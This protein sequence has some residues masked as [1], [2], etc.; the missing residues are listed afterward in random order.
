MTRKTIKTV[1]IPEIV[2]D[3]TN[4]TTPQEIYLAFA[5]AKIDK[6]LNRMEKD[7]CDTDAIQSE[8]DL[9]NKIS[10]AEKTATDALFKLMTQDNDVEE[11]IS[12]PTKKPGFLKRFWNWITRKK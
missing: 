3:I 4:C 5:D 9:D 11:R 10:D 6:Y 8:H 7:A 1:F 12:V 2:V